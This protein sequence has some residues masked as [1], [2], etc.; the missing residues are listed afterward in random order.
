MLV[1]FSRIPTKAE[2]RKY[3]FGIVVDLSVILVELDSA[4]SLTLLMTYMKSLK[5]FMGNH[6]HHE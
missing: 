1:E 6:I 3:I 5:K 4:R 2:K